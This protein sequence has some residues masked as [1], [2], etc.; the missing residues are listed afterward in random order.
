MVSVTHIPY[1][2]GYGIVQDGSIYQKASTKEGVL[3]AVFKKP[4]EFKI[5]PKA[6]F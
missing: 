5:P 2:G 4:Q 3:V 6:M 1:E